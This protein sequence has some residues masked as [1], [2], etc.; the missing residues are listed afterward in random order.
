MAGRAVGVWM[1]MERSDRRKLLHLLLLRR[2][3]QDT[4]IRRVGV[5]Y[6]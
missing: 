2:D 4:S 1:G 6:A 5:L 3:L